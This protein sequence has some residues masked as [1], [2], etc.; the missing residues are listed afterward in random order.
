M[1][2]TVN[3]LPLYKYAISRCYETRRGK[4]ESKEVEGGAKFKCK[5]LE[6]KQKF[7][8][9]TEALNEVN[10][11]KCNTTTFANVPNVTGHFGMMRSSYITTMTSSK[12]T[13]K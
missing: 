6:W 9:S 7:E 8:S 11:I 3:L 2:L 12:F 4:I 10:I 1:T 13:C 5:P